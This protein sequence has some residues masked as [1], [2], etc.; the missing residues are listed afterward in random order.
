MTTDFYP[1]DVGRDIVAGGGLGTITAYVDPN[2][3]TVQV[4]QPFPA[5]TF[6]SQAWAIAGSPNATLTP[7]GKD[8]VGA[9]ITLTLSAAGWRGEDAGKYVRI[10]GGLCRITSIASTTIA[11][12]VIV[13]TMTSTVA[14]PAQS[15]TLEGTMWGDAFGY[16][17]C[18]T[19]YEQRTWLA[20]SP[21]FPQTV[22]ASA[23]GEDLDFTIG[24][25]DDDAMSFAIAGGETNPIMHLANARGLVAL[26]S[27]GEFSI[28]GGQDKAL[29]PTNLQVKDQSNFG[30]SQVRPARVGAEIYFVQRA[31]RKLRA[32]SPN[33]YDDG[34]YVAPDM[35][36]LAE[37]VTFSGIADIAYQA[38]P[39]ALLYAVRNDGQIATLTADRDQ[40]VF[41]WSRQ[42]TQGAFEAVESVPTADGDQV[43]VVVSRAVNGAT[44]RFIEKFEAGLHT[45]CA[46]TGHS[47]A[48]AATWGGL[49][50]L[51]GR[52]VQAKGDGVYLGEFVVDGSGQITLPRAANDVEIGLAYVTAVKT[53]TPE[54]M[55]PT[56]SSQGHQL[57]ANEVKVRLLDT[58]GCTVNLQEVAFRKLGLGVLDQPPAPFT[59]DKKAGNLGWGDGTYQTLVQQV[60]PYPF[61]L[62]AV[63]TRLTANE[64]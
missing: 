37:H 14:A 61:H 13:R 2:T 64:G 44:T 58:I 15:W 28:R 10:N 52:T 42:I 55:G 60:L 53:L 47:D 33:Q 36:V 21:G 63:I 1:A 17:R 51:V 12:A 49:S 54:F 23:L 25:L 20:G 43:F 6:E 45:D 4:L 50:H 5:G 26:T 22:W 59:G 38:D 31:S 19:S 11:N 56:G 7:S 3:V 9:G 18:G 40:D 35:A 24:V 30:T 27:A 46:I 34:Q 57:S 8:P 32:L 48:G 39:D 16:P 29:T 41:A 62:L